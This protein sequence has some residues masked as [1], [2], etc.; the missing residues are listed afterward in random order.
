MKSKT[1]DPVCPFSEDEKNRVYHN[2]AAIGA[3]FLKIPSIKDADPELALCEATKVGR[4]EPRILSAALTWIRDNGDLINSVRLAKLIKTKGDEA[5]MGAI[6]EIAVSDGGDKKLLSVVK[7]LKPKKKPELLYLGF[8]KIIY[9]YTFAIQFADPIWKKWGIWNDKKEYIDKIR[10]TRKA[11]LKNNS[12]LG[13]RALLGTNVR[14]EIIHCV[15]REKKTY[16]EKMCRE[17]GFTYPA[18]YYEVLAMIKNGLLE[19]ENIGK[20]R[21][22]SLSPKGKAVVS[23]I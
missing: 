21:V 3:P 19:E 14:S 5:I 15:F 23:A 6:I 1:M 9:Y 17:I 12:W 7:L 8:R 20:T 22:I 2:M 10:L 18:I 4:Y 16:V 13:M 11:I